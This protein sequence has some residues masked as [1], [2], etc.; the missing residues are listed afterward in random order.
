[1]ISLWLYLRWCRRKVYLTSIPFRRLLEINKKYIF[2]DIKQFYEV[3]NI[4]SDIITNK[5]WYED[6][7]YKCKHNYSEIK[8]YMSELDGVELRSKKSVVKYISDNLYRKYELKLVDSII[9]AP[10][11]WL[12]IKSCGRLYT[13]SDIEKMLI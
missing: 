10:I 5:I 6:L 7:I 12:T 13:Q 4:D 8:K 2:Y 1:M 9:Y 3:D 11:C